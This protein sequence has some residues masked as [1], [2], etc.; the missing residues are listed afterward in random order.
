MRADE[1]PSLESLIHCAGSVG[2][3][4][5]DAGG[6]N[7]LNALVMRFSNVEFDILVR[8]P[9]VKI[10][11]SKNANIVS[12]EK[13]FFKNVELVLL[14]TGSGDFEKKA[15]RKAIDNGC[16]TAVILDHFVNYLAR[17]VDETGTVFP[18]HCF[19]CDNFSLELAR[20]DLAPYKN[21]YLCE[22]YLI[23]HMRAEI[24]TGKSADIN[25]VLYV[26][27]NIN[28]DW[29]VATA[30]W[31]VAFRNFYDNFYALSEFDRIIVRPHPRDDPST[32]R[33]LDRYEEVVFDYR[34]S[35]NASL[36][37]VSAVVGVESYLL[38]LSYHCGL[39]VYT[40]LPSGIRQPR[41]P[42]HVFKTFGP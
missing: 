7:I 26:L 14:G 38:Y 22:N 36:S 33:S 5:H 15:L 1:S 39:A 40:S 21:I 27:E 2:V 10:F 35:P 30:P 32:Y 3:V 11:G 18:N 16:Q 9:A 4:A 41:L 31:E 28:E 37:R 20:N 19:V 17:F 13:G 23:S 8:G 6:A 29:G 25:N 12:N 42:L 24:E 34:T